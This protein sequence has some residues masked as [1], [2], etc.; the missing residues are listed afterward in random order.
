MAS[1][2]KHPKYPLQ[3][4]NNPRNKSKKALRNLVKRPSNNRTLLNPKHL[5]PKPYTTRKTLIVALKETLKGTPRALNTPSSAFCVFS[6]ASPRREPRRLRS[7]LHKPRGSK[8]PNSRGLGPKIHTLNG[9]CN[10]KPY[11]LGV[12]TLRERV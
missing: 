7:A 8:Y 6:K 2:N 10:L 1:K 3:Y 11:Y 4:L 5:N 12:W 9:F